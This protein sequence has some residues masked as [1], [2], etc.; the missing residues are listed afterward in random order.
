MNIDSIFNKIINFFKNIFNPIERLAEGN[1]EE[2]TS[3]KVENK[4]KTKAE[5]KKEKYV[6]LY[7]KVRNGEMDIKD[8]SFSELVAVNIMLDKEKEVLEKDVNKQLAENK[9][10]NKKITELKIKKSIV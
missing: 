7:H 8:L 1:L 10:Q 6:E 3:G 2:S 4:P 9:A 5:L